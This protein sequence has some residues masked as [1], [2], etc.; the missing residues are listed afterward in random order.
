MVSSLQ[1]SSQKTKNSFATKK[2]NITAEKTKLLRRSALRETQIGTLI[3]RDV[4]EK[5]VDL[6]LRCRRWIGLNFSHNM[7]TQSGERARTRQ[8]HLEYGTE[9]LSKMKGS[10]D[11]MILGGDANSHL[12]RDDGLNGF[13]GRFTTRTPVLPGSAGCLWSGLCKKD[14]VRVDSFVACRRRVTCHHSNVGN[15]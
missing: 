13:M 9:L 4:S 6:P 10:G 7:P 8:E 14:L 2:Q 5:A 1:L 15:W 11:H 12:G 3:F